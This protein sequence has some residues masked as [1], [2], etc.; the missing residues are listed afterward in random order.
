MGVVIGYHGD[1]VLGLRL[2]VCDEDGVGGNCDGSWVGGVAVVPGGEDM[3]RARG[4]SE[5]DMGH[6]VVYA[7]AGNGS[8]CGVAAACC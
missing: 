7:V 5:C 4:S 8:H 3:V 2:E 6:V 1:C